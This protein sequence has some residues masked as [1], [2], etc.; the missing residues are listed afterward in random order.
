MA[1]DA[2]RL[3]K[4]SAEYHKEVA[5]ARHECG[6]SGSPESDIHSRQFEERR[7]RITEEVWGILLKFVTSRTERAAGRGER[8]CVA[9]RLSTGNRPCEYKKYTK[10]WNS[11]IP[12][13]IFDDHS[14]WDATFDS[15]DRGRAVQD[16][17]DRQL[18]KILGVY[19]HTSGDGSHYTTTADYDT[20][21]ILRRLHTHLSESN[22]NP[23]ILKNGGY[24]GECSDF[25]LLV[26]W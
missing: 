7:A 26:S 22:L 3:R 21:A 16:D 24:P 6:A 9:I 14:F 13:N 1:L 25:S 20:Q 10:W 12:P 5:T 23:T 17:E 18:P 8:A 2:D 15:P 19:L 11:T 4:I